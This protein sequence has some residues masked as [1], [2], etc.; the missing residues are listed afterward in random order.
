VAR[1]AAEAGP[2]AGRD[3]RAGAVPR[4]LLGGALPGPVEGEEIGMSGLEGLGDWRS[5]IQSV[6]LSFESSAGCMD[7]P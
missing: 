4:S 1:A 6:S 3:V 7:G 2:A 5:W